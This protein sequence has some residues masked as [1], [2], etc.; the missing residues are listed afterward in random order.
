MQN[1]VSNLPKPPNEAVRGYTP[2]APETESLKAEIRRLESEQIEI[3]CLIGGDEVRTGNLGVS[4]EPHNH[5]N[6][7]AKYHKAGRPEVAR[8]ISAALEARPAWESLSPVERAPIFLK[9][10]DLLAGKYRDRINA[11]TMLN[12][13]KNVYQAEIDA[14]CELA[15]FWRFNAYFMQQ[16]YKEQPVY[17]PPGMLNYTEY[18]AL[19]G[20]VFAV[21]PFNFT[22][23]GG[24]LAGAPAIMGNTVVWKPASTAVYSAYVIMEVLKEAGLPDGVI[25]LVPGSGALVGDPVLASEWFAGIHFTGSTEVFRNMWRTI[26]NG[27]AGYRTY[28]RIVGETGGKDFLV[29]HES[30]DVD[31]L[32]TAAIRGAFE[33]QGQKCSALS[34]MYVPANLWPRVREQLVDQLKTVKIGPP[35]DFSN[36]MNAVI[37]KGAFDKTKGYIERAMASPDARIVSG[38]G[39]DDTTGYYIEPTLIEASDPQYESMVEEIF[40]PVLTVYPYTESFAEVLALCDRTS[41]YALTGAVF[42]RDRMAVSMALRELRHAAGNF[43]IN[44]KPTGAVVGQQPFGGARGSGTNDKAGSMMNLLRWTSLRTVKETFSSPTDYRYPFMG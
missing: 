34:R 32:V 37:D 22:S 4:I 18:R 14:A 2:G 17:S 38:G 31:A 1:T 35:Q 7:L 27:I 42:A 24:N 15:D 43:Y 30:A 23:I 36:F 13:S 11:A 26:G 12:Q 33:Y 9:A 3:P 40:A 21:S 6:K 29:A 16:I 41:E 10:A 28:P 39:C 8:A 5:A 25:N 19:E 20:F 44:D